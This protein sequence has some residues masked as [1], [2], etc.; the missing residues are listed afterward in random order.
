MKHL[1]I[2]LENIE[3]NLVG[4]FEELYSVWLWHPGMG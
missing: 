2:A 3:S 4:T 1:D